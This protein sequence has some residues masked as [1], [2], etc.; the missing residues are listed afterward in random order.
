MVGFSF[1]W[2][3]RCPRYA[4]RFLYPFIHWQRWRLSLRLSCFAIV[5]NTAIHM[6]MQVSL[7]DG[8]FFPYTPTSGISAPCGSP[9]GNVL[10]SLPTSFYSGCTNLYPRPQYIRVFSS[11]RPC[12]PLLPCLGDISLWFWFDF[13]QWFDVEHI[14][15]DLLATDT[16]SLE[17]CLFMSF[18]HFKGAVFVCYWV[19][20]V[21]DILIVI[22]Y[23][24]V[25]YKYFLPFH[26]LLFILL[27]VSFVG[28]KMFHLTYSCFFI[29]AFVAFT[30]GVKFLKK[31]FSRPMS[32]SFSS[33]FSSR[34]FMVSGL[35]CTSSVP[36]E[37][38]CSAV[39][40]DT[41]WD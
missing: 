16:S 4:L 2:P 28:Q 10:R 33:V 17:K 14:F 6:G 13:P 27:I 34:R 15:I 20:W 11:L 1:L 12:Q 41:C 25:V 29:L 18:A 8:D 5:N 21:S 7:Q 23:G 22:L 31:W 36:C 30:C 3:N 32:E 26:W 37:L 39:R 9:S 35:V 40:F 19:L 24:Y 38:N